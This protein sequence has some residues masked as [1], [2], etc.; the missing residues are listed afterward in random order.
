M[1]HLLRDLSAVV[2][3]LCSIFFKTGEKYDLQ[4]SE[5]NG[6]IEISNKALFRYFQLCEIK[7]FD[8]L[9]NKLIVLQTKN[10]NYELLKAKK[11]GKS[12]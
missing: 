6:K 9:K 8:L 10:Q 5:R 2:C 4:T 11:E 3:P 7:Y 1:F 12:D